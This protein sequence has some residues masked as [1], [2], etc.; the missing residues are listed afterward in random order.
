MS[1]SKGIK[2]AF[3][4]RSDD[5]FMLRL[6]G[7]LRDR[8]KSIAHSRGH[9]MNTAIVIALEEAFPAPIVPE[10][11]NEA[12]FD[13]ATEIARQWAMLLSAMGQDPSENSS[14]KVIN[15]RLE[16]AASIRGGV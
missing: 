14:L 11:V 12:L 3:A 15:A 13:A 4:Q 9:S 10:S 5:K 16:N 1:T 8:I 6:P 7:D 2:R